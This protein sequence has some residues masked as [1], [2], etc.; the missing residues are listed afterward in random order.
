MTDSTPAAEGDGLGAAIGIEYLE[1]TDEVVRARVAI[2]DTVRQPYGIVHGGAHAVIAESICSRA[3]GA[4]VA[5][6]G[7]VAIGM[8]NH[9]TFLRPVSEGHINAEAR[10]RH[11]GRTTWIWDC[12]LTDDDGRLCAMVRMTVAV[13]PRP[14]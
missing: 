9:A 8:S 14:G 6:E 4:A 2:S 1:S 11:R 7:M 3:T 13:R 12:E 10:T 5:T